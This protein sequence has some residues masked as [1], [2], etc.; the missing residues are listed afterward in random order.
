VKGLIGAG[1]PPCRGGFMATGWH[2]T[3][4]EWTRLFRGWMETPSPRHLVEAA[5]FFDFRPVYGDLD[6]SRIDEIIL[7]SGDRSVFLALLAKATIEFQPPLSLFRRIREDKG[8]VDLKLGGILPIASLARL[9]ALEAQ[10][11]ARPT[12]E[13]FD[14]AVASGVLSREGSEV[15]GEA[16]RFLLRLRLRIQLKNLR[17]NGSAGNR[18]PLEDLSPLERQHLKESFLA[19]REAQMSAALRYQT[20][21]LG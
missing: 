5:N 6:V 10:A 16:F 8:G 18:A 14:A 17:A 21:R 7:E 2:R 20:S 1:F 4:E 19:I 11:R 12:L 9:Y 15:L 3:L 13:R